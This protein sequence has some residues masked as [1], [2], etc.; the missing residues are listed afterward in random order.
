MTHEDLYFQELEGNGAAANAED[1]RMEERYHDYN[2]KI[3]RESFQNELTKNE[4]SVIANDVVDDI[5]LNGNPLKVAESIKIMEEIID[6]V[7]SDKRYKDYALQE[8]AKYGKCFVSD[9]GVKIE[10]MES[11]GRYDYKTCGDP[12]VIE[13]EAKLKE[14]QEFLKKLP[15]DGMDNSDK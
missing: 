15:K 4:I 1:E 3:V 2:L 10:P 13:L 12:V 6:A 9:R 7:K 11:G 8:L 5:M 14:R